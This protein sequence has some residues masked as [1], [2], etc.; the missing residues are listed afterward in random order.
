MTK[1][2]DNCENKL[3]ELEFDE[4]PTT[5]PYIVHERD[6]ARTDRT[7]RRLWVALIIAI[8]AALASNIGW[9]IY[10]SQ[11][12]TYTTTQDGAGF[13]NVNYGTQEGL[14]SGAEGSLPQE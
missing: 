7:V 5:I 13:N 2:C 4:I 12:E 3:K 8:V 9:L 14:D 1:T 11:F 10:E 6:M